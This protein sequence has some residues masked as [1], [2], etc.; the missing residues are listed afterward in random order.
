MTQSLRPS[1]LVVDADSSHRRSLTH[2]LDEAGWVGVQAETFA[3]ALSRLDGFAYDGLIVDVRV[4]GGDGLD[5]LDI[6]LSKYPEMRCVVT[7]NFGSIHTAVKAL[8]RGAT[9][10]LL[11]PVPTAQLVDTMRTAFAARTPPIAE[12]TPAPAP[13]GPFNGIV[14]TGPAMNALF[15]TLHRVAP[16]HSTVLITGET[17]TGKELVARTIHENSSRREH[18]FVAFNAAAIPDGLAEAE[19][20]GHVKGA[21]TG[22]VYT[23]VG[24]FEAA[25]R[26]TLFIDEVSSMPL[27]LQAKVLRALQEREIER[28]GTTRPRKVNVRVVAASNVDLADLVRKGLFREDLYYRLNV[29]RVDLPPLRARQED[30]PVLAQHFV[31]ETCR[32]NDLA[33][34]VLSQAALQMLMQFSWP[35]NVRHLQNAVE[36]AVVMSGA[37]REIPADV[38][39]LEVQHDCPAVAGSLLAPL[40]VSA[41]GVMPAAAAPVIPMPDM[42]EDGINFATAISSVERELILTYLKRA[43]GNK[44]KAARMLSLRRT[45]LID[46]LHRLGMMESSPASVEMMPSAQIAD[47]ADV[48]I[49]VAVA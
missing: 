27:S 43:G 35:G 34:K 41:P 12:A 14:G 40:A 10:Y 13:A 23:R 42:P 3:D 47:V 22:A 16:M 4:P 8:K 39:P 21:F 2:A 31:T 9:D 37:E 36:S 24:R 26:G 1:I 20:F 15:H 18:P 7:A 49:A 46:K 11:K 5:V 38:L 28:V 33:P 6:A 19:L 29:V 44:R 48:P 25:D 30:I 45:T 17:G 32:A